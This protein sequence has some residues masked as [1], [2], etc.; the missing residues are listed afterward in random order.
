VDPKDYPTVE[1]FVW[2][3]IVD[4]VVDHTEHHGGGPNTKCKGRDGYEREAA[5]FAEATES[6]L[7]VAEEI[8]EMSFPARAAD[9]LFDAFDTAEFEHC[10][11]ARFF[12]GDSCHHII[13][14]L[15]IEMEA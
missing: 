2:K 8:L 1:V 6:V 12:W 10:A 14:N 11:S 9:F 4:D 3:R 15:T 13:G 5:M 7:K